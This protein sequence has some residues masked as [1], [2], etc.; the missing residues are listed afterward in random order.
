MFDWITGIIAAGGYLGIAFLMLAENVFPPIPSELVMPLAGF[1]AGSGELNLIGVV[2]AG[3]AGSLAGA[4]FWYWVGRRLGIAR[5]QRL[6]ARHGRWLTVTPEEI[7]RASDWFD[8]HGAAAVLLGRMV[9]AVRTFVS[10]PAGIARMPAWRFCAYSAVGTAAWSSLLA[11]A[12]ALLGRNYELVSAW[13]DPVSTVI[14]VALVG[15]YLWRVATWRPS[16]RS[17]S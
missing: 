1:V 13:L 12:G 16:E 6:A 3:S 5:L 7:G 9:P 10:V 4:A 11:V 17:G 8:R 14:V 15:I 2:V